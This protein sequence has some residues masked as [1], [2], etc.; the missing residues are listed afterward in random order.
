MAKKYKLMGYYWD[1]KE[2]W[3]I[4]QDHNGASVRKKKWQK[5]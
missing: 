5:I 4:Y 1:G 2:S 3:T